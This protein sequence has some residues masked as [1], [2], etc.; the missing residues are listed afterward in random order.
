MVPPALQLAPAYWRLGQA[1]RS[2]LLV[3]TLAQAPPGPP[4]TMRLE[5]GVG[6]VSGVRDCRNAPDAIPRR[7]LPRKLS[8]EKATPALPLRRKRHP[9][10]WD[11]H[12]S[13][14]ILN[15]K[16]LPGLICQVVQIV[17]DVRRGIGKESLILV[18]KGAVVVGWSCSDVSD[19]SE[20]SP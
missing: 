9:I 2:V 5:P 3:C 13:A 14:D 8:P 17:V 16:I 6:C 20:A 19:V 15:T 4:D 7:K 10:H 12:A 11:R 1:I 18:G